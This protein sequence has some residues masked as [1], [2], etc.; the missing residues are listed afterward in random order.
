[1]NELSPRINNN[2]SKVILGLVSVAGVSAPAEAH[3]IVFCCF[4][5]HSPNSGF[6][7]YYY[8]SQIALGGGRL[9]DAESGEREGM[10]FLEILQPGIIGA[11]RGWTGPHRSRASLLPGRWPVGAGVRRRA[12]VSQAHPPPQ[13]DRCCWG[14]RGL[15]GLQ[16]WSLP[17]PGEPLPILLFTAPS[18][19]PHPASI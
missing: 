19:C 16:A 6:R 3:H 15:V 8:K 13:Q 18:T 9:G 10:G 17:S 14:W 7:S 4:P 11:A 2:R 1:M 12:G 5:W